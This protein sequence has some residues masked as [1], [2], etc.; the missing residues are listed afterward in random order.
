MQVPHGLGLCWLQ[1]SFILIKEPCAHITP[2]NYSYPISFQFHNLMAYAMIK[3]AHA[4]LRYIFAVLVAT[5]DR[6][7]KGCAHDL[8][9]Q[10]RHISDRSMSHYPRVRPTIG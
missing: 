5:D 8:A 7:G 10:R 9:S 1:R 6:G 2:W 3:V 4:S